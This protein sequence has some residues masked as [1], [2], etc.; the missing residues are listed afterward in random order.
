MAAAANVNFVKGGFE[1]VFM[2][3]FGGDD[4]DDKFIGFED[5]D[6]D[7][8]FEFSDIDSA[9]WQP[10]DRENIDLPEFIGRPGVTA[11]LPQNPSYIDFYNLFMTPNIIETITEETNR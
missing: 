6:I 4:S 7:Q 11:D 2:E 10:G 3:L 1:D 5:V 9:K 8:E